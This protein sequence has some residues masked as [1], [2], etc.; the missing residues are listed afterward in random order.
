MTDDSTAPAQALASATAAAPSPTVLVA[1]REALF[2]EALGTAL[3]RRLD[4]D[5]LDAH[6]TSGTDAAQAAVI[7][8]PDVVVLDLWLEGISAVAATRSILAKSPESR[9]VVLGWQHSAKE[10]AET[11]DAG[12]SGFVSKVMGL[13]DLAEAIG[14]V[15]AGRTL[16]IDPYYRVAAKPPADGAVDGVEEPAPKELSVRE[17]EVLRLLGAG[18]P[19]EDIG[20]RLDITPKTA[21]THIHRIL[22]KTGTHSQLE[23]LAVAR[24]RGYL[25]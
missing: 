12:A 18:L 5:V 14:H 9:V 23:A 2:A 8:R 7:A 16:V 21:Q 17:L 19:I 4:V 11:M 3:A 13:D 10:L 20:A 1:D 24:Q 25:V 22:G 15:T 6:P